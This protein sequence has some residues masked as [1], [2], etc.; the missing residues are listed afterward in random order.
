MTPHGF[1][2]MN[3]RCADFSCSGVITDR[4]AVKTIEKKVFDWRYK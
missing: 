2:Y 4:K 3:L 1:V